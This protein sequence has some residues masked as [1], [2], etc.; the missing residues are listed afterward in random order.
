MRLVRVRNADGGIRSGILDSDQV[1]LAR[2]DLDVLT[3]LGN[4]ELCERVLHDG[5]KVALG[6]LKLLAPIPAP[7]KFIGI[8]F[9]V[10]AHVAEIGT[11]E[12]NRDM[13]QA[14]NT[15]KHSALAHPDRRNPVF[16]NK[17]RTCVTGPTD[18]IWMPRD[19]SRLDYEGEL[20]IVI[21]RRTRRA[22]SARAADSIAGYMV[23]NDVSVR[24]WQLDTP[25]MWLGKSF[26]THGPTGPWVF[27]ADELDPTDL[28][29]RTWVNGEL[30]QEGSTAELIHGPTEI[31]S[32]LS[33]FC[34]LEKG[35]LIAAGTPAG[36]GIATG[37]YLRVGDRVRVEIEELGA[38]E[39]E[40]IAE[41]SMNEGALQASAPVRRKP[42]AEERKSTTTRDPHD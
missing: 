9:N 12:R 24:D 25:T 26:E 32:I 17:Q 22:D 23:C 15:R 14:L 35:D 19:S 30:R 37:R 6:G 21:G 34:T 7:P 29:L 5:E 36:V 33:Q 2:N 40:V 13:Q 31:V 10:G 38:I 4:A 16:F 27:T 1:A 3:L 41:P 8:G 42:V 11:T 20:T 18:P 28:V 39:N